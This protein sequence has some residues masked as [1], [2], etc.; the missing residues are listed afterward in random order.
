MFSGMEESLYFELSESAVR[1]SW[2]RIEGERFYSIVGSKAKNAY[3]ELISKFRK[4][5]P[6][7]TVIAAQ[8]KKIVRNN[9][10]GVKM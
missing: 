8:K 10:V 2:T 5:K 7:C 9:A 4:R 1:N 3:L 6:L